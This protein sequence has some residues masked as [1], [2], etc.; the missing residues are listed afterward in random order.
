MDANQIVLYFS[1]FV[2]ICVIVWVCML[3]NKEAF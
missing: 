3:V 1:M 2:S